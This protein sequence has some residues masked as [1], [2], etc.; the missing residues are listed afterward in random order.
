[1]SW[2]VAK[3]DDAEVFEHMPTEVT[4]CRECKYYQA[5]CCTRFGKQEH[6]GRNPYDFCS[7]GERR[8]EE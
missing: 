5:K 7:R 8:N 3:I 6:P 4:R 2:I 1:M